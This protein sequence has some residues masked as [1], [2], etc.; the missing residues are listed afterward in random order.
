MSKNDHDACIEYEPR[1]R[2]DQKHLNKRRCI[3]F[4]VCGLI[5]CAF[6]VVPYFSHNFFGWNNVVACVF[7][8]LCFGY[9]IFLAMNKRGRHNVSYIASDALDNASILRESIEERREDKLRSRRHRHRLNAARRRKE[10]ERNK[11]V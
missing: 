8:A 1:M 6:G 11:H 4:G 3:Q 5:F 10:L 9:S 7:A 2:S